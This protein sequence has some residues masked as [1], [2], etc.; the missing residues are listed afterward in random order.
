L[1][2]QVGRARRQAEGRKLQGMIEGRVVASRQEIE[3]TGHNR[4]A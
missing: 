1:T 4:S 2:P 3:E